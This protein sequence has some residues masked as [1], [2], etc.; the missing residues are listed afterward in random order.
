MKKEKEKEIKREN[1]SK[2]LSKW[3]I[4]QWRKKSSFFQKEK[5]R[6]NK[7]NEKEKKF[8]SCEEKEKR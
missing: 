8:F 7:R 2:K 4:Q 5:E 3:K 6:K 1:G